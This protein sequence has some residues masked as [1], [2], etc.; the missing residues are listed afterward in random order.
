MPKTENINI[1]IEPE[2]KNR[3]NF[4]ET[5]FVKV[6]SI[7]SNGETLPTKYCYPFRLVLFFYSYI[8]CLFIFLIIQQVFYC[9]SICAT[10][11]CCICI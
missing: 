5:E 9:K 6:V 7:L 4:D 1:R 8:N 3:N 2:L 10:L 11:R